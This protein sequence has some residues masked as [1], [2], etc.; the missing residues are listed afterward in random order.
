MR[1]RPGA[2]FHYA[3]SDARG[4]GERPC[5]SQLLR[6]FAHS[7]QFVAVRVSH[8]SC[9]IIVSVGTQARL[10]LVNAAMAHCG[11][12]ETVHHRAGLSGQG[13]RRSIAPGG[14]EF[15]IG[16]QNPQMAPA[17]GKR[18]ACR[19][20]ADLILMSEMAGRA[21]RGERRIVKLARPRNAVAAKR[22]AVK[23]LFRFLCRAA[24]K[25]RF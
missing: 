8:I 5:I 13:D 9:A 2:S 24:P 7:R 6:G 25:A 10:A 15:E 12:M 22:D 18:H 11:F 19:A 1:R 16:T 17:R 23:H 4:E 14:R 3:A 20:A 21:Q